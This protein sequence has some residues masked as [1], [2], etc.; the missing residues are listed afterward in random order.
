MK[1]RTRDKRHHYDRVSGAFRP[2]RGHERM[3]TPDGPA[4]VETWQFVVRCRVC[5]QPSVV[6]MYPHNQTIVIREA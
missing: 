5:L 3:L 6:K 4:L 2:I 1:C